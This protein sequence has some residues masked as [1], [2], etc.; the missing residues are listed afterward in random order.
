MA[1]DELR[2][3]S[4]RHLLSFHPSL[5]VPP[6]DSSTATEEKEYPFPPG[7]NP[8]LTL[9]QTD[10]QADKR[11]GAVPVGGSPQSLPCSRPLRA[12]GVHSRRDN[13]AL[14]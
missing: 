10:M 4:E 1:L 8:D 6:P 5:M 2:G 13:A 14:P 3:L 11:G 7:Y 12:V 9:H